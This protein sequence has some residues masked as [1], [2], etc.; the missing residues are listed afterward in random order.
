M[1]LTGTGIVP[2]ESFTLAAGDIVR[3]TLAGVGVL[4]N[5]V[6]EVGIDLRGRFVEEAVMT[7]TT[8]DELDRLL[9]EAVAAAAVLR[10]RTPAERAGWLRAAADALDAAADRL[11]PLAQEES[12]LPLPRLTGELK[13]TTFQLRLFADEIAAGAYLHAVIDHAD[14]G[15]GMGPR[16][17]LRRMLRAARPRGRLG[18]EQLP[19]RLLR[20]GR[21]HRLRAGRGLPCRAGRA[22]RPPAALP[23]DRRRARRGARGRRRPAGRLRARGGAGHRPGADHRPAD[24][25]RR[26]HRLAPRRPRP[27]RPG[28]RAARRRSRS[29]ASSAASTPRS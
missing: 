28:E 1:L 20:R 27:V 5:P 15:W 4:E 16:P 25:L 26:L 18:G 3:V 14:P 13:R 6:R 24:H 29:T 2:P 17:D 21:R 22:P 23:R 19:V 9:D 10:G 7:D 11:L 12:R 8:P